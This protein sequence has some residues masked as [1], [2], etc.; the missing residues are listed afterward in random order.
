MADVTFTAG[1]DPGNYLEML[2]GTAAANNGIPQSI[3][4]SLIQKESGWNP[5]AIGSS[6]EIG[7]TQL[8]PGTAEEMGVI[9]SDVKDNLDGGAAYLRAQFDKYGNWQDA[10]AAYNAGTPNSAAGQS[11]AQSIIGALDPSISI[12]NLTN[13]RSSPATQG[14]GASAGLGGG[15]NG[16][17]GSGFLSWL[18]IGITWQDLL[19]GLIVIILIVAGIF[20]L[21]R[22]YHKK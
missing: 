18:G 11:Y 6:G 2:A 22:G 21:V 7:L 19:G 4:F 9:A 1:G 16:G 17:I 12:D 8:M 13:G 14:T 5:F 20:M 10:L 3:F 15:T